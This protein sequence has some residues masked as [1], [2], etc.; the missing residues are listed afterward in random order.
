[1]KEKPFEL[2]PTLGI[3][4]ALTALCVVVGVIAAFCL[5]Q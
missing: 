5:F 4:I 1:M 3:K 2:K